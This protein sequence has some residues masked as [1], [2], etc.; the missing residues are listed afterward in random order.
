M[1]QSE[2]ELCHKLLATRHLSVAERQALPNGRAR[3]SVL[4]VAVRQAL[5]ESNWFPFALEPDRDIGDGVV[6][7]SRDGE[8]W[9]HEQH[10]VGVMRFS[11][12]RSFVVSDVS[13]AVRAYVDANGGAPIDGVEIDWHG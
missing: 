6:L 13:D 10:E 7:E 2:K 3:F 4:V 11:P 12:I 8:F 9:V 5:S 1:D